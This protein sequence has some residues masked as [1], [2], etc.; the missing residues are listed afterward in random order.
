M[1]V[2]PAAD[3]ER[4]VYLG[5][6]FT[7]PDVSLGAKGEAMLAGGFDIGFGHYQV[8]WM[9]RDGRGQGLLV[10]LG[11]GSKAAAGKQDLPLALDPNMVA[12][13]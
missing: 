13:G 8:D 11:I 4:P 2:T 6:R 12:S 7:I 1:R 5:S 9:M 10:A 3:I